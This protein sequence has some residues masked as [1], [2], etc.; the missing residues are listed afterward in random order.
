M[1]AQRSWSPTLLHEYR[2]LVREYRYLVEPFVRIKANILAA[3]AGSDKE[4]PMWNP[5]DRET[6][7]QV[8]SIIREIHSLVFGDGPCPLT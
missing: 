8:D 3:Q 7:A 1:N 6:C 5:R 4:Q 2:E